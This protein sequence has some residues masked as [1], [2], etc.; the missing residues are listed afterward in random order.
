M[1]SLLKRYFGYDK[2]RPMQLDIINH[3]LQKKDSLVLMPTGGGKSLCYQIPA[4][5]FEGLTVVISPLISLMQDQVDNLKA[6]GIKAEYINSTLSANEI[7]SI[8]DRIKRNE[9]KLLYVAPE[10]LSA[11]D[12]KIFLLRLNI[13][14]IA[15]DEAHCISEWGHDFRKDYRNLKLLKLMFPKTPLIALTATATLKVR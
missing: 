1:E 13:S 12:F 3:V 4:I 10:R 8:K 2:F 14:L 11:E 5:Q 9:I 7:E 6:N 15:I